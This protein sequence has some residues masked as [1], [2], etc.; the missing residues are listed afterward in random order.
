MPKT[1]FITGASAG[2]GRILTGKLLARGDRVAATIRKPAALDDLKAEH[3][4]RL[5][6]S[7]LDLTDAPAIRDVVDAAFASL[8]RID[9]VVNN[10]AYGLFGAGEEV[11]LAQIR[12]AIDTNLIGSMVV[13][14][15]ALPHLRAQKGGRILQVSS[16]GGQIAFPNFSVYHATKWGIEGFCEAVSQEVA[17]FGIDLTIVEP[18][19]ARTS[20]GASL[21]S[22][23]R[24]A[25]YDDTPAGDVR[26]AVASGTFAIRGNPDKM[27]DAMI[28]SVDRTPAPKRLLLGR[29]AYGRVHAALTER[30]AWLEAQKEVAFSTEFN[31]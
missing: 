16:E 6:V 8:G 2:F 30:L 4:D 11:T 24:M 5:D 13:I 23:P 27:V 17:P 18:G 22:P 12:H 31:D 19:P 29:D 10:A 20:F 15:S 25:A 26:R 7:T 14:R 28:A 3:G 21:V 9:V 1:W